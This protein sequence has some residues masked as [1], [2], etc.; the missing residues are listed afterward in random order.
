MV[1]EKEEL[2]IQSKKVILKLD[3]LRPHGKVS[4]ILKFRLGQTYTFLTLLSEVESS[5]NKLA[6]T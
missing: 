3:S 1:K 4:I 6:L 2:K 5:I